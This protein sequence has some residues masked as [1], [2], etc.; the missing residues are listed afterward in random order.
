MKGNISIKDFIKS[1]KQEILESIDN[2]SPLFELG[3]IE[4]EIAFQV[5]A[6]AGAGFNLY[7]FELNGESKATQTHKVKISL[8]PLAQT[9]SVSQSTDVRRARVETRGAQI[10]R[11]NSRTKGTSPKMSVERE[12]SIIKQPPRLQH[13]IGKARRKE[14][15]GK[16]DPSNNA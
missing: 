16:K 6:T 3:S 5:E 7:V 11:R 2:E 15:L 4:L 9:E 12:P 14:R 8:N 13:T 1:V 10:H